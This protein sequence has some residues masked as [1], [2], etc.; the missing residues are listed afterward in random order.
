MDRAFSN[1]GES[2]T[3]YLQ[4][5]FNESKDLNEILSERAIHRSDMGCLLKN[6]LEKY[7]TTKEELAGKVGIKV[8]H[9]GNLING[10]KG[11]RRDTVL[12][13]AFAFPLTITETNRLLKEAGFDE[14]YMKIRRDVIIA[15]CLNEKR[16][17]YST[18]KE[19]AA[20]REDEI[21]DRLA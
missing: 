12:A 2:T 3:S 18:N 5:R 11:T 19:L 16:S 1:I 21:Y 17:L 7:G 6:Y 9:L 20:H 14:L 10:S 15:Y 4:R 13:I 8:D